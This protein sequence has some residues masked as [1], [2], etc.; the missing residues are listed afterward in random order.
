LRRIALL[1]AAVPFAA[2]AQE[3]AVPAPGDTAQGDVSVTIYNNDLALVQDK[4]TL[5]LPNGRTR[6][7]FA[8]VSASIRPETVTLSGSGVEIV[9]QNFDFD[10]LSPDKLMEKAVGRT[11]TLVRTNPET[12]AETREEAR[13]L[14]NNGGTVLQIGNRIEVLD[15]NLGRIVFPSLPPTLRARPTLSITL[16]SAQAGARPVTLNYLSR[17]LGWK[18]DYVA[19]FDEA[20]GRMDVQGWITLTNRSGTTYTNANTILVAGSPG[21]VDDRPRRS[22]VTRPGTQ[23]AAREQLGDYYLYPLAQRTTIAQAQQKQ[24]SFLDVSG[25]PASKAYVYSNGWLGRADQPQSADTVLRFSS[26]RDGGLGD[27]LPAGDVRVYM[28]DARGSPQFI[29]ESDIPHTPMGSELDLQT[30]EAFDVKVQPSVEKRE[31]I[32]TDEWERTARFRITRDGVTREVLREDAVTYWR[33]HMRYKLTNAR[34]QPVV[35]ELSQRGLENY[36][37]DTRVSIESQPGEQVSRDERRWKVSVPA[38]G[39]AVLTAAFDTRY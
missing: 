24:V 7:E 19:L 13:V 4:R 17:G 21:D 26:S 10:L 38:N 16:D 31:K 34:P 2:H 12:G 30:G 8:D 23:S 36:W 6:Q 32:A 27:A 33:T 20:A 18:A 28:R 39:E 14:A 9:E 37:L 35:V 22:V 1:L 25:A 5:R 15:R 3:A 29:G 11:V